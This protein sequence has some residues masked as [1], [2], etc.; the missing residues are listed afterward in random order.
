MENTNFENIAYD[1]YLNRPSYVRTVV[2]RCDISEDKK[3]VIRFLYNYYMNRF[4]KDKVEDVIKTSI[5][6]EDKTISNDQNMINRYCNFLLEFYINPFI[7]DSYHR[8]EIFD[9]LLQ[10]V[11]YMVGYYQ[12]QREE[13]NITYSEAKSSAK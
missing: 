8:V 11:G 5:K 10:N 4:D 9:I 12:K 2:D 6:F 3:Q 7:V 1:Y 13:F